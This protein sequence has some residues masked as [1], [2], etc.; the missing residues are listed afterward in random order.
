[1]LSQNLFTNWI[2]QVCVERKGLTTPHPKAWSG[3]LFKVRVLIID[4]H[5]GLTWTHH[6]L[7]YS[8]VVSGTLKG[9]FYVR[10]AESY[11]L[12]YVIS[13]F[14]YE[15]WNNPNIPRFHCGSHNSNAGL[16]CYPTLNLN[17]VPSSWNY[18]RCQGAHS[19]NFVIAF[20]QFQNWQGTKCKLWD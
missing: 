16:L 19:W 9:I 13:V 14:I 5:L 8:W 12:Y 4:V 18:W 6:T 11:Y 1:M 3:L 2:H 7:S 10:R 15:N 17:A 20:Y